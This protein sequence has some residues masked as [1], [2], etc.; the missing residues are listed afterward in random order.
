MKLNYNV[1][2]ILIFI[3][4]SLSVVNAQPNQQELSLLKPIAK[5]DTFIVLQKNQLIY[6]TKPEKKVGVSP[7]PW[8]FACIVSVLTI[9][10]NIYIS[11]A[12]RKTSIE[13]NK[14]DFNKTILSANRQL[15]IS[16]FRGLMSEIISKCTFYIAKASIKDS[17]FSE[18]SLL[19]T[20]VELLMTNS[21]TS[22]FADVISKLNASS[23]EILK[24]NAPIDELDALLV[25]L[26]VQTRE[27]IKNE[28]ELVKN[29]N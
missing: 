18:L 3:L 11:Y 10:A 17:E 28:W 22:T 2:T 1:L 9:L 6:V 27:T 5:K 13:I 8:I 16:E 21:T 29:G 23:Y 24:E 20:K 19:L 15:W 14:K 25:E 7:M 26:K 12:A 4:L